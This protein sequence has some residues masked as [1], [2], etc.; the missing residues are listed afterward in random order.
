[1]QCKRCGR[2]TPA[3]Q[4]GTAQQSL[5]WPRAAF[6]FI[7]LPSWINH[8]RHTQTS[9][10]EANK[11]R[12]MSNKVVSFSPSP[13]PAAVKHVRDTML[14]YQKHL[15]RGARPEVARQNAIDTMLSR[16]EREGTLMRSE[17]R[18][19]TGRALYSYDERRR[20][21]PQDAAR[22]AAVRDVVD[23]KASGLDVRN[24]AR[25][26]VDGF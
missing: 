7:L 26:V 11:E 22:N 24:Y 10:V 15:D 4:I 13:D 17:A 20:D 8:Q 23:P 12:Q 16:A 1:M 18:V 2:S 6:L 19:Y 25:Q 21:L 3:A 14:E 9:S 5:S